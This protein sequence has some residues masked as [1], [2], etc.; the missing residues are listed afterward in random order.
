MR[1]LF[2]SDVLA[3][4]RASSTLCHENELWNPKERH[5]I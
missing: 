3:I 4:G 5:G 1:M 2:G